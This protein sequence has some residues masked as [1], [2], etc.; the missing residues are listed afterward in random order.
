MVDVS[1]GTIVF[2]IFTSSFLLAIIELSKTMN[3]FSEYQRIA[4][5][6]Q[7]F[8]M[9][10]DGKIPAEGHPFNLNGAY[11]MTMDK[12]SKLGGEIDLSK[13]NVIV[14]LSICT[15]SSGI[16]GFILNDALIT[17]S[18]IVIAFIIGVIELKLGWGNHEKAADL[19]ATHGRIDSFAYI[20]KVMGELEK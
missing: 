16:L 17:I 5:G 19:L 18:A 9:I 14:P 20:R 8:D 6:L 4:N 13:F 2:G 1:G 7:F 12:L 11:N 3:R 15:F 10:E